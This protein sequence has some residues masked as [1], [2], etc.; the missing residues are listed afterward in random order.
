MDSGLLCQE[1]F[2]ERGK[3]GFPAS[4][5]VVHKFKVPEVEGKSLLRYAPM[6]AKPG[7]QERPE[8]LDGVDMDLMVSIS[9]LVS[10]VFSGSMAD[11]AVNI[12]PLCHSGINIVLIC[13]HS[14]PQGY[15][16]LD[17]G[18]NGHLLYVFQ[19]L[20]DN[21][22]RSLDDTEDRRLLFFESAS[23]TGPFQTVSSSLTAF[24]LTASGWPLWPATM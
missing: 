20:D 22:S 3:Q 19:H 5:R 9:V 12:S 10:G 7:A 13:K 6:W 21:L 18:R 2:N 11:S 1:H 8:T 16:C 17:D 15:G 24:F 14:A 4:S 23:P